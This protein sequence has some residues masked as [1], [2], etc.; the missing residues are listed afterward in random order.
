MFD[1][2]YLHA[3]VE[4]AHAADEN[5]IAFQG[6]WFSWVDTLVPSDS[7]Q[8]KQR[9]EQLEGALRY[10]M[11]HVIA[12]GPYDVVFGF[13]QGAAIVALLSDFEVLAWLGMSDIL[14]WSAAICCCGAGEGSVLTAAKTL[15]D[16]DL[17][18]HC[19]VPSV[20]LI[21]LRDDKK[22]ESERLSNL[23]S[24]DSPV[25]YMDGGHE[26][27]VQSASS[28][29]VRH[30]LKHWLQTLPAIQAA[31]DSTNEVEDTMQEL[32][33]SSLVEQE[34]RHLPELATPYHV[35]QHGQLVHCEWSLLDATCAAPNLTLYSMLSSQPADA[36]ALRAPNVN[37]TVFFGQILALIDD[38]ADLRQIGVQNKALVAY[39]VPFGPLGAAAF[40]AFGC[41]TTVAPLDPNMT[42]AELVQ[43]LT[44]L[45]VQTLISFDCLP[46]E[47]AEAA[48]E[49]C[50]VQLVIAQSVGHCGLFTLIPAATFPSPYDVAPLRTAPEQTL[51]VVRTSGTTSMPK[52][53]PQACRAV[54]SNGY[55]L[56][57]NLGLAATDVALNAMPLFHVGGIYANL[58]GS[59]CSGGS[60]ICLSAFN[61]DAFVRALTST[62]ATRPTWYSAVP[63]IHAVVL[64]T[65]RA[66]FADNPQQ[67]SSA[68]SLRFIRSG[69]A[70]LSDDL[71]QSLQQTFQCPIIPT[72]AMSEQM[73]IT[74]CSLQSTKAGSVGV[75]VGV[76][77]CVVST[78]LRI[79]PYGERGEVCISGR[80]VCAG[81]LQ[82]AAANSSAYFRFNGQVWFRT[83]DLGYLDTDGYLF[84]TGREKE[85]IK[86]GGEQVSPIEVEECLMRC[87]MVALAVVF[88]VPSAFW[89]QE[90]GAAVVLSDDGKQKRR[91]GAEA[92]QEIEQALR[93]H[94]LAE[95]LNAFK[96]PNYIVFIENKDQLPK[97]ST[98]K[99]VRIGL[100]EKL[101]VIEMSKVQTTQVLSE[102][103]PV[104]ISPALS[105][106]RVFLG[107]WIVYNHIGRREHAGLDE[108][109]DGRGWCSHVPAFIVLGGFMLAASCTAPMIAPGRLLHFYQ[110]RL[111]G[112]YPMYLISILVAIFTLPFYCRPSTYIPHF[113]YGSQELCQAPPIETNW[114]G[115]FAMTVV[116]YVLGLQAWPFAIPLTFFLSYYSFYNSIYYFCILVFPFLQRPLLANSDRPTYA[117]KFVAVALSAQGLFEV[118]HG[119][120]WPIR[121]AN[122]QAA[123][124]FSLFMYLFP[125]F[126]L[127]LFCLGMGT[128][129]LF[130]HYRPFARADRWKW[131]ILTDFFSIVYL[132]GV[133][134][135]IEA[136]GDMYPDAVDSPQDVR[137]WAS[138]ISRLISPM[139]VL[140]IVGLAIGEGYTARLI[141]H[142]IF[143]ELLGPAFYC[144][145]LYHQVIS[146]W[147]FYAT[148][149][150]WAAKPKPFYWFSPVAVPVGVGEFFLLLVIIYC[151]CYLLE[152]YLHPPLVQYSS[153][154]VQRLLHTGAKVDA[155]ASVEQVILQ[156]V[157]NVVGH[158]LT[159]SSNL[160]NSGLGSLT[161]I[162]L[163]AEIKARYA[164]LQ[165]SASDVYGMETVGDLVQLVEQLLKN[166]RSANVI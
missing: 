103:R 77:L 143:S 76:S 17:Q 105:G 108:W 150:V 54:V 90:V 35:S 25:F 1:V 42:V 141:G 97:T 57:R 162:V 100:A 66:N 87:S 15:I 75:P 24:S 95:G 122:Y 148:R 112:I 149:G 154:F 89:G 142:R 166:R 29:P 135:W 19:A 44:Q 85:L 151:I 160:A 51:F 116:S 43:A 139:T 70:A 99:F 88:A 79:L 18:I 155:N 117:W 144:V 83:G 115:S 158:Q 132:L 3:P 4:S 6:P 69:A 86:R 78:S 156:S 45:Q 104:P 46:R 68:H 20:H 30:E 163:V 62:T 48:A 125:P 123:G 102:A 21:G 140:W 80:N 40:L 130:A 65:F 136:T 67:L 111:L 7:T 129:A 91:E 121:D 52:V 138:F 133:L 84:L 8:E 126:W 11:E 39:L 73:P 157:S 60:V 61:G 33:A 47:T 64:E 53:V 32:S 131:G 94:C 146:Q 124:Y 74:Q 71:A 58:L 72:Y 119:M 127:P 92:Q 9:Q 98:N 27:S 56:A 120:Y 118:L 34:L 59:L 22:D 145:Y 16:G 36:V 49:K 50:N 165:L 106:S 12:H 134:L 96:V 41:Q 23:F 137:Y 128:Y 114:A 13:S 109:Y 153:A 113:T 38:A 10:V 55:L 152:R 63:T 107:F 164:D 26:V 2:T 159:I 101:G 31:F 82:N 5:L 28:A 147:Y 93:K 110:T 37:E 14:P 161:T 81:Y